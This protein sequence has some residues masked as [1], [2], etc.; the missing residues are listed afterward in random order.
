MH[1]IKVVA[2]PSEIS[3]R[4]F[5]IDLMDMGYTEDRWENLTDTQQQEEIQQYLDNLPD[6]PYYCF[7][8]I[9]D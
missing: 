7:D 8:H 9:E 3:E 2:S 6:Q 1:N 5:T 4:T